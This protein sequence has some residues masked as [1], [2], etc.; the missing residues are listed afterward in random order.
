[1]G[2]G[3]SQRAPQPLIGRAPAVTAAHTKD[4]RRRVPEKRTRES[5]W[6]TLERMEAG[7]WA[8][9]EVG[10]ERKV[11]DMVEVAG[12]SSVIRFFFICLLLYTYRFLWSVT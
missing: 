4:C 1:M 11:V 7:E 9:F 3:R 8:L 10:S 5:V 6:F 12:E 2:S